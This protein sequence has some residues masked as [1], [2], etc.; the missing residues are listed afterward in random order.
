MEREQERLLAA[1]RKV[2]AMVAT[3][4]YWRMQQAIGFAQN[5]LPVPEHIKAEIQSLVDHTCDS[6]L[7]GVGKDGSGMTHKRLKVER[8][9]HLED[10]KMWRE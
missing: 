5:L 8:V 4:P 2:T 6:H 10:A 9:F 7:I 3:P 1:E